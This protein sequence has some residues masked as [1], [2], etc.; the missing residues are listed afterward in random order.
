MDVAG[1]YQK[2]IQVST[3]RY[4]TSRTPVFLGRYYCSMLFEGPNL[5]VQEV[6]ARVVESTAHKSS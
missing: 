3:L 4:V 6:K 5:N 1:F 2:S